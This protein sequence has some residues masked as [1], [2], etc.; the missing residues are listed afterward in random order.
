MGIVCATEEKLV[1][2]M[3]TQRISC[4]RSLVVGLVALAFCAG[5]CKGSSP[6]PAPTEQPAPNPETE[7]AVVTQPEPT[8][9]DRPDCRKTGNVLVFVTSG[10]GAKC[11]AKTTVDN[12][13]YEFT[14]RTSNG[15]IRIEE[16]ISDKEAGCTLKF[17]DGDERKF[18][19][20]T[21]NGAC[22]KFFEPKEE[23]ETMTGVFIPQTTRCEY[24]WRPA[25]PGQPGC[26]ITIL[27]QPM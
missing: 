25:I 17:T 7:S 4:N 2:K 10:T 22:P 27:V 11:K 13:D 8:H 16:V 26:D 3:Q 23:S 9:A 12:V 1:F 19:P 18:K 6:A 15:M 5:G 14:A 21:E 24:E 20:M